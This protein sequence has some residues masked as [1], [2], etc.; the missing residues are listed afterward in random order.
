MKR[1]Y[2]FNLRRYSGKL[3]VLKSGWAKFKENSYVRVSGAFSKVKKLSRSIFINL[4]DV[5]R[6]VS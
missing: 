3:V 2:S 6:G 5:Y 4:I 1:I